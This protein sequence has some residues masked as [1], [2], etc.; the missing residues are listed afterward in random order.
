MTHTPGCIAGDIDSECP[1]EDPWQYRRVALEAVARCLAQIDER[2]ISASD[3]KGPVGDRYREAA[4]RV[5]RT[6]DNVYI[7]NHTGGL[8]PE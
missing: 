4:H 2:F 1:C 7:G 6:L 5:M 8:P 3:W